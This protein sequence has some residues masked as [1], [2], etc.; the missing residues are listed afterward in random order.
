MC[1]CRSA[2]NTHTNTTPYGEGGLHGRRSCETNMF[3]LLPVQPRHSLN[4]HYS[5]YYTKVSFISLYKH[6]LWHW[7]CDAFLWGQVWSFIL[8]SKVT[9]SNWVNATKENCTKHKQSSASYKLSLY[10]FTIL[11]LITYT[12]PA[13]RDIVKHGTIFKHCCCWDVVYLPLRWATK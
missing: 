10:T 13:D 4:Q 11:M 3:L 8:V 2:A 6:K 9:L 1:P 5:T 7:L 12:L